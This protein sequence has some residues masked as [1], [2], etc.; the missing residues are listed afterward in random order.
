MSTN[1][2]KQLGPAKSRLKERIAEV[3]VAVDSKDNDINVLKRLRTKLSS[4]L[5]TH[6]RLSGALADVTTA[7]A[8]EQVI[9]DDALTTCTELQLDGKEALDA[10]NELLSDLVGGVV[11][12]NSNKMVLHKTSLEIENL[13]LEGDIKRMTLEKLKEPE[14]ELK[15]KFQSVKLPKWNL[16]PFSG[17]ITEWYSF[18]DSFDST[19][20]SNDSVSKI[21]KFK[22]LLSC[23]SGDA[24][25]AVIGF[26]LQ[27]A[28]Y[29]EVVAHLKERYDKKEVILHEHYSALRNLTKC[30]NTTVELRKQFNFIEAQLR[31]L[32]SLGENIE[33]YYLISLIKSKL[34]EEINLKLEEGKG[35]SRWKVADLRKSVNKLIYARE[36]SAEEN[37]ES[38]SVDSTYSY[39]TEV[40]LSKEI[41]AKCFFC[42]NSHWS[43]ECQ[44]YKSLDQRKL[45]VKGRCFVCLSETHQFRT[46]KSEK[47]CFH[48]KRKGNH[49]SSLCPSKFGEVTEK[50]DEQLIG[51]EI[52]LNVTEDVVMKTAKPLIK[53]RRTGVTVGATTLLDTGAKRTYIT[54][55]KAK[56][57]GLKLG[58]KK[59]VR[60][61]TFGS[62]TPSEMHTYETDFE[63]MLNDG[64]S[65]TIH[66]KICQNITGSVVK[67]KL[68]VDQYKKLWK[69]LDIADDTQI[70]GGK[71][72]IDILLGNDYYDDI[73]K[74]EK[75]DVNN[76]GLYLVNSKLG[77]IFSGRIKNQ[78]T[79]GASEEDSLLSM[80]VNDVDDISRLWEFD[81]VGIENVTK[82]NE[83]KELIDNLRTSIKKNGERYQVPWLWKLSKYELSDN[84]GLAESRLKS[85]VDKFQKNPDDLRN[86]DDIIQKHLE[87]GIIEEAPSDKEYLQRSDVVTH[88]L[89]HHMVKSSNKVRVVFEGNA[90]S[91]ASKRSL[92]E[93][94]HR[95]KNMIS[96]LCG[97]FIRWRMN[98][99]ALTA[100]IKS[101]YLQLILSPADRDCTRFLWLKDINR[102]YSEENL[103]MYRFCR[104]IWG[105]ISASFLLACVILFHLLQYDTDVSR[106]I[107]KNLYAD[108]L[109]SGSDSTQRAINYY[110]ETKRMF[111]EAGMNMCKWSSN[112][113]E[114]MQH[115]KEEDRLVEKEFKVLGMIWNI[116]SDVI[117][118]VSVIVDGVSEGKMTKRIMLK[119]LAAA[120]DPM[121]L[122]SPVLLPLKL[123]IQDLWK[124]GF[125]WDKVVPEPMRLRWRKLII[126]LPE[127]RNVSIDRCI[128]PHVDDRKKKY[129]LITFSDA[130]KDAYATAVYL[131]ILDGYKTHCN[132]V[133]A[134]SRLTPIKG[135][136]IPRLE[137][138]GALIGCR[139]SSFV[140]KELN[141]PGIEQT[142]LTD[143]K[144]VIEW[145]KSKR[146]L[147][148][149]V[150]N[151]VEEIR[152][153][154]IRIGYVKSGDNPADIASRGLS[155]RELIGSKLW[156]HGP[157][158]LSTN[159]DI[160][161]ET[162]E[163][164]DEIRDAIIN[165]E[166][167]SSVLHEMG[168]ITNDF[169]NTTR[170]FGINEEKYSS[171]T[172][173]MRVTAWCLRFCHNSKK[174]VTKRSEQHLTDNEIN[175]A[176]K[177]WT[178]H[179]QYNEFPDVV[180]SIDCKVNNSI[181][182]NLGVQKDA[183][184]L[185]RCC[186]RFRLAKDSPKLLPKSSHY[187]NLIIKKHHRRLMHAGVAQTLSEIRTEHWI[188]QG[189]SAVQKFIRKCLICIFWEG[190]PFKTPNFAP[191]PDY[192]ISCENQPFTYVG[193]DYL[194][195]LI[196]RMDKSYMKN[197][198]CLFTC[199][200]IR[201]IHLEVVEDMTTESFL[202]CFRRFI[203]R[204]GK[205]RLVISDNAS[206]L[207]LGSSVIGKIWA[208]VITDLEVQSYIANECIKW[209]FT[210]EYAPWQG[211]MY[212]RL[213]GLTKRSLKKSLG[214]STVSG[215]QLL[216]FVTEVEAVTNSRPLTYVSDDINSSK[217]LSPSHF[218]TL[219]YKTGIPDVE[220]NYDPYDTSTTDLLTSWRKGQD[221]LNRFWY[222]WRT[223]YLQSLRERRLRMK[224]VKG[225]IDRDP[226]VGE[227]VIVGEEDMP[228]GN[229]KV[230]RITDLIVSDIDGEIRGAKL[231]TSTGTTIKRPMR[232]LY[233]IEG[234][235][236]T[237]NDEMA[238]PT[239]RCKDN[240][241][242]TRNEC[243]DQSRPTRR[244]AA[245]IAAARINAAASNYDDAECE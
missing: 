239:N 38:P 82:E 102:P 184:G 80:L 203:A 232:L 244:L 188:I 134:R 10:V 223:E 193:I 3:W 197:W 61:N 85:L 59:N 91:H 180:K 30:P 100:D 96:N 31:S 72:N 161:F 164:C 219:N 34:P 101:A 47:P 118:P 73:M 51:E 178:K 8:D 44:T 142:L 150:L 153:F 15:T 174:C 198:V 63:M 195:P 36:R 245:A 25:D 67:Q 163:V 74:T 62:T 220:D 45:K 87:D 17:I 166:K 230:G 162:Y 177:L 136:S 22:Y 243:K 205:P 128:N 242:E 231:H 16:P 1:I 88:Y 83:D 127:L 56:N 140:A 151:K 26:K 124:E 229:W 215:Q 207:K 129:E 168:L 236:Y 69:N 241:H 224:S 225:E 55:A 208:N 186:G 28:Q 103:Q 141:I 154:D 160:C 120:Y 78:S 49:H 99:V 201:A 190:T 119:I 43:D 66:A 211:G 132:L 60:L 121:G 233:P 187:T 172:R 125:T 71:C 228:R 116:E 5:D 11:Q 48:C 2:R 21:D 98:K 170:P 175:A 12:E 93:C 167:G 52:C 110:N 217:V 115:I 139:A 7:D 240:E 27:E 126:N 111:N 148:R 4:N 182:N 212:E 46:C 210:I 92:N 159:L 199:I 35:E 181:K 64:S 54:M 94:L 6:I 75:I 189:R 13:K 173:L 39:S 117:N 84:F 149:F 53:N 227:V 147:K 145:Y 191:Y 57:L 33:N 24:K 169:V 238:N 41:K 202:L 158:W 23:L 146:E 165:E 106:D 81:V 109:I 95:G 40:L 221:Q 37:L 9:V 194:G 130:S 107:I 76:D 137:L 213:I 112:D 200:N 97:I 32:Q 185:L 29:D 152:S 209:K 204:R 122:I 68:E 70:K 157:D 20:H 135:M 14:V 214:K 105:V 218:L 89:P 65:K 234:C 50:E 131:R 143:S 237:N 235:A 77:W 113:G 196:V 58:E 155:T 144:C 216:T 138:L 104:V 108:N 86:Y 192:M 206:Q 176:R 114:V 179:I 171:L 133:F 18:W 19:I 156:W 222:T 79:I 42:N 123:L 226:V 90:K 183:D